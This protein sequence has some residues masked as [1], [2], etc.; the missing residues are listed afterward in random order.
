MKKLIL[1]LIV[2]N[3]HNCFNYLYHVSSEQIRI[4][5]SRRL[6]SEVL[7]E[8]KDSERIVKLN[9]IIKVREFAIQS[10]HL[11]EK[12]GFLYYAELPREE[13][14]WNVSASY[15]LKFESY[16]WWFPV[17]GRVPYKGFF[18]YEKAK[19]EEKYL[20][21]KGFDTKVR[22]TAGYSTLGWFSDPVF[23]SQLKLKEDELVALVIHEL[24][25]STVY[26]PGDSNF[27]ESYASFIEET[28]T[29][30]FYKKFNS[31]EWDLVL[32]KRKK[33]K[34]ESEL[35]LTEVKKTADELKKLYEE[36][37]LTDSFKYIKKKEIIDDYKNRII[38]K[39]SFFRKFD[40][41]KFKN[42]KLNNENFIGILRY[43]S[44]Q[45]F[46]KDKLDSLNNDFEK[47]HKE[48]EKLIQLSK[49]ERE[50]LLLQG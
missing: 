18:D 33:Y 13:L 42:Q 15:P 34:Q 47:F 11:N 12:G 49:E 2:L 30:L 4:L 43:H 3:L 36:T 17:A 45:K 16:T 44:G 14:G 28:G 24:S 25:H 22:I 21:E 50:K 7:K 1:L 27:N 46:F 32:E 37:N 40:E 10:L 38:S 39:K 31:N 20:I 6:I 48:M 23:S 8:D 9:L 41:V 35:I 5:L 29:E 26:F 19:E